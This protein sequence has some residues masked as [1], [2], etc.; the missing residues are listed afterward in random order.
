VP[1]TGIGLAI[2]QRVVA[3]HD[4]AISLTSAP[5]RGSTFTLLIPTLQDGRTA[6]LQEELQ[7]GLQSHP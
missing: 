7:E 4:G 3:A 5:G 1:G 6:G 2:V